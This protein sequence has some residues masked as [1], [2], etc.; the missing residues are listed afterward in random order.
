MHVRGWLASFDRVSVENS[1]RT[2]IEGDTMYDPCPW[3]W[4]PPDLTEPAWWS[5]GSSSLGSYG[6]ETGPLAAP[7]LR[8]LDRVSRPG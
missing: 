4:E 7:A 3:S 5:M 1:D 6:F 8:I 2:C